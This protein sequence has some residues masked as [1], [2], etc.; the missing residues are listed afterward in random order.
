MT[1]LV[2]LEA[3]GLRQAPAALC[4]GTASS[5]CP[6]MAERQ[7]RS[8]PR[9]FLPRELPVPISATQEGWHP[10]TGGG[11]TL[12]AGAQARLLST[13]A[14]VCFPEPP[15][16]LHQDPVVWPRGHPSTLSTGVC[17]RALGAHPLGCREETYFMQMEHTGDKT[18][19]HS[20]PAYQGAVGRGSAAPKGSQHPD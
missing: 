9:P 16:R 14:S 13:L 10:V 6:H 5:Q 18:S 17:G 1:A 20:T 12:R 8:G 3:G 11:P 4:L 7:L 2:S 19:T 15:S